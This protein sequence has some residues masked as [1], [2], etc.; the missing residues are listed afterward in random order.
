MAQI[1]AL[2]LRHD[3]L[4]AKS[5]LKGLPLVF[6]VEVV[7]GERVLVV[8]KR[9]QTHHLLVNRLYGGE[10]LLVLLP[11]FAEV[12]TRLLEHLARR[13]HGAFDFSETV[14]VANLP[15]D[16]IETHQLLYIILQVACVE[17]EGF[18]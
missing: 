12:K 11:H 13:E 8:R 4:C 3:I 9:L 10:F 6:Y 1:D 7:S 18:A 15:H 5:V 14:V 16:G 17:A 2:E